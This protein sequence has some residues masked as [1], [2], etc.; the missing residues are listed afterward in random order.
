MANNIKRNLV[1]VWNNS[2][3]IEK[4]FYISIVIII[5]Y[6]I[7]VGWVKNIEPFE[8]NIKFEN[9]RGSE[10]YDDFYVNIYDDLLFSKSKNDYEITLIKKL[11]K[12]TKY[13]TFLDV[14]SGTGHLVGGLNSDGFNCKGLDISRSMI[15]SAKTKYPESK[16]IQGDVTKSIT[17]QPNSFTHITCM[18]FTIYMIKNK[19]KFFQ[20]CM[21]WLRPT[22]FLIIHIVDRD[23]FDPILP[24]ADILL[25]I[26]PQDYAKERIT[27]TRAA[28]DNHLY[29]AKFDLNGDVATFSETFTNRKNGSVRKHTH[30]LY[31][32][33]QKNIL[34]IAQSV[35]FIM[36]SQAE[37]KEVGY[38][39]QFIYVLQKPE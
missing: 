34:S 12:P 6:F 14:G 37:M 18:Y 11:T 16:F 32:E 9:K 31:M 26:D 5:V 8:Q 25:S 1:S 20:N 4:I 28:F 3:I 19:R 22:G 23:N 17:F 2:E 30:D 27:T 38:K 21:L 36:A 7:T 15:N 24:V 33:T 10:I 13:S 39:K 29:K 35:G